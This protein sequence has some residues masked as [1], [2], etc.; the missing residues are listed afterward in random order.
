M[1]YSC[2]DAPKADQ[3]HTSDAKPIEQTTSGVN[4]AVDPGQTKI[5]FVG[6]EPTGR[7]HGTI[8]IKDGNLTVQNNMIRTG[9]IVI[10]IN[11]LRTDDQDSA[12]NAKL[13]GH[14]LSSDF[15]DVQQYP[16][17]TF[18]ITSVAEGTEGSG[19]VMLKDAT[20]TV[21]GNLNLKGTVKSISFPARINMNGDVITTDASFNID[22]THWGLNYGNDKSLGNKFINPI[23]NIQL[24]LVASKQ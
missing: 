18:E 22:R 2:S 6:T 20:H 13:T 17:A 5:E 21:T 7:H 12:G 4:Y 3:A 11:T 10:D 15:F 19:E 8:M 23:V 24:R 16:E 1:L 14:L 9:K